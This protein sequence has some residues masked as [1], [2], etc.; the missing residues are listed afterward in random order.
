MPDFSVECRDCSHPPG[1]RH[2]GGS[3]VGLICRTGNQLGKKEL[4]WMRC[5][6]TIILIQLVEMAW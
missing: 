1:L 6:A 3:A 5:A 4:I 2:G